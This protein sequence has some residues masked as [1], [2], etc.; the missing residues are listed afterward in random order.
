MSKSFIKKSKLVLTTQYTQFN[1]L[2]EKN[3]LQEDQ[4]FMAE[5]KIRQLESELK[6]VKISNSSK[7]KYNIYDPSKALVEILTE[8]D[9]LK[10]H[11]SNLAIY[12]QKVGSKK[13]SLD[14]ELEVTS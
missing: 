13:K 1:N 12:C 7:A 8:Y 6:A 3:S 10:I 11:S 5:N 9:K 4:L 2:K 14:K